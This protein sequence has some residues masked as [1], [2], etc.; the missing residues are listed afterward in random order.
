MTQQPAPAPLEQHHLDRRSIVCVVISL[1]VSMF[2]GSLDQTIVS[3]ALPTIVGELGGVNHMQWVTTAYLLCSTITMPVYGKL[4]DLFGRKH[5]FCGGTALF[6]AGSVVCGLTTSML[7]LIA[8]RAIQGLGGGGMIV[9]SQAIVADVFPP[10]VRGKY[11]GIMGAAFGVSMVVGPLLGGWF[12]EGIGW[13]WCFWT[14]I[15][16]GLLTLALSLRFLPHRRHAPCARGAIDVP[17]IAAMTVATACLILIISWGGSTFAWSSPVIAGL[18][19]GCVVGVVCLVAA[20]R[21]AAEPLIPLAFFHNRNF[22][23]CTVVGLFVMMGSMGT[24]S[25]LPTYFQVVDELSATAAGYM[26][27]PMMGGLTV[28]T[29]V[30]GFLA[31]R[32]TRVKFLPLISCAVAACVYLALSRMSAQTPLVLTGACLLALGVGIGLGQQILVLIVQ[33][34]FESGVVGTATA[35]NNFFR[36]IG[37]TLGASVI[38]SI[39]TSNLT[40]GLSQLNTTGQLDAEGLTPAIVHALEPSVKALV[41]TIYNDALT[42]A[43][44]VLVPLFALGFVLTLLLRNTPLAATHAASGHMAADE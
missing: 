15:P 34:E 39:F 8:G 43:F 12:T 30:S 2:M 38:G 31:E 10:K 23:I 27:L 11:M 29:T 13:R 14:N 41:Q 35:S 5:L 28:A 3:T 17:G 21:H 22:V 26:M 32:M 36:E 18:A 44:F 7:G 16:L 24:T 40:L 20:E 4:G 9:L 42:P 37:A 6:I 1:M 19:V 33:N 25:Y